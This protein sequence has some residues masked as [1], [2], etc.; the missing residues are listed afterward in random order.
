MPRTGLRKLLD[1]P[2]EHPWGNL[3]L[4]LKERGITPTIHRHADDYVRLYVS[5]RD[6]CSAK[7]VIQNCSTGERRDEAGVTQPSREGGAS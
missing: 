3:C 1:V 6:L 5:I 7:T 4:A 2:F